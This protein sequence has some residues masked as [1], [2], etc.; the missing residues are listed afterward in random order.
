MKND[1]GFYF[2]IIFCVPTILC[3]LLAR[4]EGVVVMQWPFSMEM[5]FAHVV[6]KKE[7]VRNLV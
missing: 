2:I 1:L 5:R 7:K 6:G 4:R 3:R